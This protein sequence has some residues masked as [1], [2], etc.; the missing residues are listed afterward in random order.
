MLYLGEVD[1]RHYAIHSTYAF[2]KPV[3]SM[4]QIVRINRVAVS[5]LSLGQGST[6]GSLADRLV[7]MRKLSIFH[8]AKS[9]G[10]KI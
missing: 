6:R 10:V 7:S 4:D 2:R 1:D 5:D 9:F 3:K 8:Y